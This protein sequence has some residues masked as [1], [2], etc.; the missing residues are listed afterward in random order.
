VRA[1]EEAESLMA[2]RG[3]R[4]GMR[5]GEEKERERRLWKERTWSRWGGGGESGTQSGHAPGR[6]TESDMEREGKRDIDFLI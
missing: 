6:T 3:E 5:M 4:E 1:T 2:N